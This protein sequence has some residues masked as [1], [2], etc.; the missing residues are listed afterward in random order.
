MSGLIEPEVLAAAKEELLDDESDTGYVIVDAQFRQETWGGTAVA[1][2]TRRRLRPIS[3]LRLRNGEPDALLAPPRDGSYRDR[4]VDTAELPLAVIEAKGQTA[5]GSRNA[6]RVAITQVHR[7]LGE[8][9][10]G[11]AAVPEMAVTDQDR[12]LARELNVGLLAVSSEGNRLLETPRLVGIDSSPAASTIRFH[13]R[14]GEAAVENLTKN[15]PKN[16]LGYALAIQADTATTDVFRE[17]VIDAVEDGRRDAESLGLV[18]RQRGSTE[19]TPLGRETVRTIHY[20]HGGVRSA[21]REIDA[22]YGSPKRFID[23]CPVMGATARQ[24]L[25]AYPPTQL[26]IDTLEELS[27]SGN[28]RPTLGQVARAV[29]RDRPDFALDLFVSSEDRDRVLS[30][31]DGARIDMEAFD[32]GTVYSTHT[33]YQYKALLYHTGILTERGTGTKE[34]I[35]PD[36]DVWALET[37]LGPN[38]TLR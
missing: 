30:G 16:A 5:D 31:T 32:E 26:L 23:A 6:V 10:L 21:L 19:L 2:P 17:F 18:T 7:H 8:V 24:A 12:A 11:F 9:N 22:L 33:T 35:D 27:T 28:G 14:F 34:K 38:R 4:G 36:E 20:V 1:E 25:L 37:P 13:A 29:A 15:H 3:T